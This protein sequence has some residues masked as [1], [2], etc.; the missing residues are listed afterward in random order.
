[1]FFHVEQVCC[2]FQNA[3]PQKMLLVAKYDVIFVNFPD[4]WM[5]FRIAGFFI[6][7]RV[8]PAVN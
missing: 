4:I 2:V 5:F 3:S 7:S 1:M 8:D 6:D